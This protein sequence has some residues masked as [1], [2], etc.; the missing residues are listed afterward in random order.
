MGSG[1]RRQI[2][3]YKNQSTRR[4]PQAL[5]H[6]RKSA[7]KQSALV[8]KLV[9]C[10][11][12]LVTAVII[13]TGF[14]DSSVQQTVSQAIN[15]GV[16]YKETIA[17][18]GRAVSGEED[19]ISVFRGLTQAGANPAEKTDEE[20]KKQ[21]EPEGADN[22]SQDEPKVESGGTE[23]V[24]DQDFYNIPVVVLPEEKKT[25]ATQS[26]LNIQ[27]LKAEQ[28]RK[29]QQE[30]EELSFEMSEAELADD[31]KA[32]PFVIPPP[33]Y[34]SYDK[35]EITFPHAPP[36]YGKIT[37]PFGY[38]DH[39]VGGDASFHTGMDIAASKGT[40]VKAFADG[41][42][43]E[44]ATNNVYGNYVLIEHAN[45]IRS[46]Y[47]HNSKLCVKKGQKIKLG[48]KIA[49]VGSTGLSTGPHVHFE[50]RNGKIRLNPKYY[51]SPERV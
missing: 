12:I 11:G 45:G 4:M 48:Q 23:S 47:G 51:I 35:V 2:N 7:K 38:R 50:V 46:F 28:A 30:I 27:N 36:V 41:T 9:L 21:Q 37:S 26:A 22:P 6:T 31:T 3:R 20:E 40:T 49:E 43:L 39:P 33:S 14:Q 1:V 13:K 32:E 16:D 42:V 25:T 18:V 19:V 15:G 34:C 17:A 8:I 29:E 24:I 5:D 44:A 10:A